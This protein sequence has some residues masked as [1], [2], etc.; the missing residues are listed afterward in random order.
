MSNYDFTTTLYVSADGTNTYALTNPST[1]TPPPY[2]A[3]LH[4]SFSVGRSHSLDR[5][6]RTLHL[7]LHR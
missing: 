4:A 3:T 2:D 1:G 5:K 6:D 7:I